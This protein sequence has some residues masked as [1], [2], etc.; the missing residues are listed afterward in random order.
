[1]QELVH[2]LSAGYIFAYAT[3]T[4]CVY[5]RCD[6]ILVDDRIHSNKQIQMR[7]MHCIVVTSY[8]AHRTNIRHMH[9]YNIHHHIVTNLNLRFRL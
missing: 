3:G 5:L 1:M 7:C 8:I 9:L 2:H 4:T 6:Y